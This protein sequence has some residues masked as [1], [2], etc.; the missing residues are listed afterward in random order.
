MGEQNNYE[1]MVEQLGGKIV[2]KTYEEQE[3]VESDVQPSTEHK[4]MAK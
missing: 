4:I 3:V 1:W 2:R